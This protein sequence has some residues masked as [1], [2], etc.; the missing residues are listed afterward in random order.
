[1]HKNNKQTK[2]KMKDV[3]HFTILF[4]HPHVGIVD[5]KDRSHLYAHIHRLYH[6]LATATLFLTLADWLIGSFLIFMI[7]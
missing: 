1:M 4:Y 7:P 6:H 5:I 3:A 2:I